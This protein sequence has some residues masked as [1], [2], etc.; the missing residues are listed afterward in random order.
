MGERPDWRNAVAF[1]L[2]YLAYALVS[3]RKKTSA[4]HATHC[5][6]APFFFFFFISSFF[7]S[8]GHFCPFPPLM[9]I[10]SRAKKNSE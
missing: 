2:I 6:I 7:S 8:F 4:P 3:G 1:G 5:T 10:G 9:R